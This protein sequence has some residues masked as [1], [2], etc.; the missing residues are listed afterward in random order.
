MKI[1][2]FNQINENY[3]KYLDTDSFG[4][5]TDIGKSPNLSTETND[6]IYEW[7]Q[8]DAPLDNI[9]TYIRKTDL[10]YN[11][12]TIVEISKIKNLKKL[13]QYIKDIYEVDDLIDTLEKK[14]NEA[15]ISYTEG[16]NELLYTF[17]EDLMNNNFRNF[18]ELFIDGYDEDI[19]WNDEE[20]I[21]NSF[22][23][24][25]DLYKKYKYEIKNSIQALKNMNKYNL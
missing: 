10:D 15:S 2:K 6:Y 16:I 7:G 8:N 18:Y 11:K 3:S 22:E 23:V 12:K 4:T 25:P 20:A 5:L 21:E 13:Q 24:H 19:D 17:Q 1:K 9:E 14:R